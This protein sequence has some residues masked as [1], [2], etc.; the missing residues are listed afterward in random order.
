MK[1]RVLSEPI[2]AAG[3]FRMPG[4]EID[5]SDQAGAALVDSGLAEEIADV[6]GKELAAKAAAELAAK[7]LAAKASA[8]PAGDAKAADSKPGS[9]QAQLPA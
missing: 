1:V 9:K 5:V 4:A 7:E 2:K 6:A 8:G 3:K